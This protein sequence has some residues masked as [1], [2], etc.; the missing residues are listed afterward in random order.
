MAYTAY[1]PVKGEIFGN[2][3]NLNIEELEIRVLN[4]SNS[5]NLCPNPQ[6][7]E[8]YLLV[9]INC[10]KLDWVLDEEIG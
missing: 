8:P 2:T 4:G 6:M 9:E 7:E 3:L 5:S 1:Y 10:I